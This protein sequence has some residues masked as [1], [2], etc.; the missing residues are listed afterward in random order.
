MKAQSG[1]FVRGRVSDAE[2]GNALTYIAVRFCGEMYGALTNERGEFRLFVPPESL[3]DSLCISSIGYSTGVFPIKALQKN[4]V[5]NF[6]LN[7]SPIYADS[8]YIEG[9][10]GKLPSAKNLVKRALRR[11]LINYPQSPFTLTGYYRD[12]IREDTGY[13]NLFEAALKL[14]DPGFKQEVLTKGKGEILQTRFR[15]EV[16]VDSTAQQGYGYGKKLVPAYVM[17]GYGGNEFTILQAHDPIRNYDVKS[18]SFVYRLLKDFVPNHLFQLEKIT[19]QDGVPLY[20]IS[21]AYNLGREPTRSKLRNTKS[22]PVRGTLWIR[23]DTYGMVKFNY[24]NFFE[25]EPGKKRYEIT[26]EYQDI[27]EKLFLKYISMNNFFE[28]EDTTQTPFQV[29]GVRFLEEKNQFVLRFNR[30]PTQGP[31]ST[32]RFFKVIYNGEEYEV[33][34]CGLSDAYSI[35]LYIP[36]LAKLLLS[37]PIIEGSNL[38]KENL[39]KLLMIGKLHFKIDN[40]VTDRENIPFGGRPRKAMYQFREFFVN[41]I[42]RTPSG[43]LT[44]PLNKLQPLFAQQKQDNPQFW[45]SF[46]VMLNAPLKE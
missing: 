15:T 11:I 29:V 2:S 33:R 42:N 14:W 32:P 7:P 26:V 3:E 16:R 21:F 30:M 37:D 17:P 23:T 35:F 43:E 28:L 31:A 19:V 12:Y 13:I 4:A 41:D 34:N 44:E 25:E 24:L 8:V 22:N 1:S 39:K 18:F 5:N 38:G 9:D 45:D 20:E 27:R 10:K 6:V 46:T 40:W 36:G